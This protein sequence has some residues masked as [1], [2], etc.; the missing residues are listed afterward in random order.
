MVETSLRICHC[1]CHMVDPATHW[2]SALSRDWSRAWPSRAAH[3]SLL[4]SSASLASLAHCWRLRALRD[5]LA[6]FPTPLHARPGPLRLPASQTSRPTLTAT[7]TPSSTPT[8]SLRLPLSLQPP[9]PS[10]LTPLE[11]VGVLATSAAVASAKP[12]SAPNGVTSESSSRVCSAR[13]RRLLVL[14]AGSWRGTLVRSRLLWGS[15]STL[16]CTFLTRCTTL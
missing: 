14:S 3:Q 8:A 7:G 4:L 15:L 9:S 2:N 5:L 12:P 16:S 13:C 1:H 11:L 10:R 6:T